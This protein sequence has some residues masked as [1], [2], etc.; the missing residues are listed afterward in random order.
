ME[1]KKPSIASVTAHYVEYRTDEAGLPLYFYVRDSV[2]GHTCRIEIATI[3]VRT[4][5]SKG[6]SMDSLAPVEHNYFL[7]ALSAFDY[8]LL[9]PYLRY[10]AFERG[11]ILHEQG[12]R[13]DHV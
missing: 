9:K 4:G 12:E 7:N 11:A 13:V 5:G 6:C 2:G 1:G 10:I 3:L 8:A